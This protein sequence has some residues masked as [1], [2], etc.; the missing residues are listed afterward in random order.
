MYNVYFHPLAKFPGPR[1]AGL[2]RL[3]YCWYCLRGDLVYVL[4]DAHKKYGDVV[5]IAPNELSYTDPEVWNEIYGHRS[6]KNEVM[7]DPV[8][9]SSM[10]SGQGSII[11]ADRA[12]HGHLR[13]Q[14]SHGFSEKA[15]RFQEPVIRGYADM[16][17]QRLE[18]NVKAGTPT[19]D[20]VSW[21]NVS[22]YEP[23]CSP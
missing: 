23:W 16:M 11:N 19:V 22:R 15:L 12:R 5:R 21:F 18:E 20:L 10:S 17:M 8:F 2:S 4:D 14:I 13:K 7:K 3:W 9:Y 6:G 1:L